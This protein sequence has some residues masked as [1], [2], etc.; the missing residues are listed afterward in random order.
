M[1]YSWILLKKYFFWKNVRCRNF[2]VERVKQVCEVRHWEWWGRGGRGDHLLTGL[3]RGGCH[4]LP[5]A[6]QH[7]IDWG[8]LR[9]RGNWTVCQS[10][11]HSHLEVRRR[12][13][14]QG[15]GQQRHRT[16]MDQIG[17]QTAG[18]RSEAR[19][20][21]QQHQ[22]MTLA[23]TWENTL[24]YLLCWGGVSLNDLPPSARGRSPS[25]SYK[26]SHA[27]KHFSRAAPLGHAEVWCRHF[28]NNKWLIFSK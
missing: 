15:E 6:T 11:R 4:G 18:Q 10:Y 12:Q 7:H 28:V 22:H 8:P 3:W 16:H 19:L 24:S 21:Y 27:S 17:S 26:P 20:S 5:P 25:S 23:A 14:G 13:D 9:S 2:F 1:Y